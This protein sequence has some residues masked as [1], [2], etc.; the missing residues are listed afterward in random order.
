LLHNASHILLL[1][2]PRPQPRSCPM[3]MLD[4]ANRERH[5]PAAG[6]IRLRSTIN[7][8]AAELISAAGRI[9]ECQL[10][11]ELVAPE[12]L[13]ELHTALNELQTA[14]ADFEAKH[15]ATGSDDPGLGE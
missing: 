9:F 10:R 15:E 8:R 4:I 12:L 13:Q 6:A 14:L 11:G 7:L 5:G 1:F 3:V 2:R